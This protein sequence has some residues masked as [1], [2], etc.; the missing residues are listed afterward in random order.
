ME[1]NVGMKTKEKLEEE[2][3]MLFES[4]RA[5]VSEITS[6]T[7]IEVEEIDSGFELLVPLPCD[8]QQKVY[9]TLERRDADGENIFQVFTVCAEADPKLFEFALK[10]NNDID[11]G[12]IAIK[13]LYG[14][15]YLVILDT[16]LVRTTQP[17]EIEKS[18]L[19]LA[20]VGDDLE[21]IITGKDIR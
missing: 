15:D 18:L 6:G 11:Y 21:R 1:N 13:E 2:K 5:L 17:V 3:Q 9:I 4:L 10:M 12:A 8:R 14:K 20:E 19:T 7:R 16:Q